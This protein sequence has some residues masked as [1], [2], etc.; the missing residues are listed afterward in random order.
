MPSIRQ[1]FHLSPCSDFRSHFSI[2][3]QIG[4]RESERPLKNRTVLI[5]DDQAHV[6]EGLKE[7]VE[8]SG[9]EV[10][11]EA[12]DG[13]EAVRVAGMRQPSVVLMDVRMPVMDGLEATRRIKARW[14]RIKV[15]VITMVE[16]SERDAGSAGGDGFLL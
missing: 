8:L 1:R 12:G 9:L 10:V 7:A 15:I 6:R 4:R 11:G 2:L 3:D 13:Q 5:A 16:G 14:P